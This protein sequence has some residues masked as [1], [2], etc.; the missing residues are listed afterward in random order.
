MIGQ[1]WCCGGHW[2]LGQDSCNYNTDMLS[3][4]CFHVYT[5]T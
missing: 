3:C 2:Q 5:C 1:P 4:Y